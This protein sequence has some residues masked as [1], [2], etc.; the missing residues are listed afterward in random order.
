MIQL[1]AGAK[2]FMQAI[3]NG[4]ELNFTELTEIF[5]IFQKIENSKK[6]RHLIFI[7]KKFPY[8]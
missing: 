5:K 4:R 1:W 8:P 3:Y 7:F 6:L 2:T